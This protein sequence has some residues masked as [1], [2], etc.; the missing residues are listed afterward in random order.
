MSSIE[1][2]ITAVRNA[3]S[4]ARMSTFEAAVSL[5]GP[6]DSRTLELYAWNA[7]ISA[8][9]LV[10]L[11]ICEIVVRNAASD[12]ITAVYGPRWPWSIGFEQ[13]LPSSR[14]GYNPQ[15]DLQNAR[16][17]AATTGNDVRLWD[18]HLRPVFPN[19]D[20][21][22]SVSDL[23][24]GIYDNLERMRFLRNRIAHHEPIFARDINEELIE[25][26][27]MVTLRCKITAAW[28]MAN[29]Q[30]SALLRERP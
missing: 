12:A 29:Q 14:T 7:R 30:A 4:S 28:M 2:D 24:S 25:I 8:A 15:R 18:P 1:I 20:P 21:S 17:R 11:H 26:A 3:L 6:H 10:P 19:A 16:S 9:L 22:R 13:S 27:K 5:K 23:R